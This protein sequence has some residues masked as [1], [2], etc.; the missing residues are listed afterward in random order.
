VTGE[1]ISQSNQNFKRFLEEIRGEDQTKYPQ[2][3]R[4]KVSFELINFLQFIFDPE[5]NYRPTVYELYDAPF[6]VVDTS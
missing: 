4:W 1:I 6:F 5:P 2:G 3:E